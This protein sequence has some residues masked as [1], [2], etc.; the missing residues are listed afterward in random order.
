MRLLADESIETAIV[1]AMRDAGHDV[2]SINEL[3]PGAP[4]VRV[5]A[6][7]E[8]DESILVTNDKDFAFLAFL[9]QQANRGIVLVRLPRWRA[10][11]KASR[12]VE[13]VRQNGDRLHGHMTVIEEAGIRRRRLPS[14]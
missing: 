7:A 11:A 1:T 14:P 13:V 5:L 3:D 2:A 4:D 8:R 12:L 10:S 6:R 9:Q